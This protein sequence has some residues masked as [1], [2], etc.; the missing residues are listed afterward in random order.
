M[1]DKT[2]RKRIEEEVGDFAAIYAGHLA[3]YKARLKALD[4]ANVNGPLNSW[5]HTFDIPFEKSSELYLLKRKRTKKKSALKPSSMHSAVI[6]TIHELGLEDLRLGAI[7]VRDPRISAALDLGLLTVDDLAPLYVKSK[8]DQRLLG[9]G[10]VTRATLNRGDPFFWRA[11]LE[12][13]CR[14]Y[15]ASRG[16]RPWPLTRKVDLAFD[17][18]E[19]RRTLPGGK[20]NKDKVLKVLRTKEPYKTKY[21]PSA[22]AA[23]KAGVGEDRVQEITESIGPMNDGALER[24]KDKFPAVFFEVADKRWEE[25]GKPADLNKIKKKLEEAGRIAESDRGG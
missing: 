6:D 19:I 24:L 2:F 3:A 25:Q 1:G 11:L 10:P 18:D 15:I 23:S 12:I 7:N 17:L 14:A 13:L 16:R 9:M 21:P 8:K 4:E 5:H 20:W 22:S